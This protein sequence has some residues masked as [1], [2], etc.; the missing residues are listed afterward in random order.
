MEISLAQRPLKSKS[1]SWSEIHS[2]PQQS[3]CV[4]KQEM[5]RITLNTAITR[6]LHC[7]TYT[8][9]ERKKSATTPACGARSSRPCS[10]T[11]AMPRRSRSQSHSG[12][13]VVVLFC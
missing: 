12:C 6:L 11:S 5:H 2:N 1:L 4:C 3:L 13:S 8:A 7:I 10:C 9:I